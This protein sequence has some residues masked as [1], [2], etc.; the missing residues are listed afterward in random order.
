MR[1]RTGRIALPHA[2]HR[3]RNYASQKNRNDERCRGF[4]ADSCY[5]APVLPFHKCDLEPV[6]L[7]YPMPYTAAE[8]TPPR[9]TETTSAVAGS[10]RILVM[11]R[12]SCRSINAI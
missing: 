10:V 9:R 3:S 1:S 2:V 12:Q 4:R 7:L 8:I 6:A 5:D 11:T